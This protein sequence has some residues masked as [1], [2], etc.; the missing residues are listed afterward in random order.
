MPRASCRLR[1]R[2]R[3]GVR[4]PDGGSPRRQD[5]RRPSLGVELHLR[6]GPLQRGAARLDRRPR[7][8]TRLLGGVPKAIVCD[9]C[10]LVVRSQDNASEMHRP[11]CDDVIVMWCP[12]LGRFFF[13]TD[14]TSRP[15][16]ARST[17]L[18]SGVLERS[19]GGNRSGVCGRRRILLNG[20]L[21]QYESLSTTRRN[22]AGST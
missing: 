8:C 19:R 16:S 20:V 3:G 5:L 22:D 12:V 7:Q 14:A 15:P 10:V 4:R 2:H 18:L 21:S 1:R 11:S 6:R 17:R 13:R 9:N